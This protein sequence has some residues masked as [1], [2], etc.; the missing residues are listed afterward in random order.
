M[1]MAPKPPERLAEIL[2]EI[3]ALSDSTGKSQS[4]SVSDGHQ[5]ELPD[6]YGVRE[7]SAGRDEEGN[8]RKES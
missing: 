5:G 7:L 8:N 1:S 4:E 3:L 2:Q 6:A